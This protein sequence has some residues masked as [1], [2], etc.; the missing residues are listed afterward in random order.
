[1]AA[2]RKAARPPRISSRKVAG[3][4]SQVLEVLGYGITALE[5]ASARFCVVGGLARGYLAEARSTKDVD[6]AVSTESEDEVDNLIRSLQSSGFV[7]RELFQKKDG[8]VATVRLTWR[9]LPT[10][11]DLLFRTSGIEQLVVRDAVLMVVLKGVTAPVIRR[12]HLI[13]MKLIAARAQD[14]IDIEALL[15]AATPAEVKAVPKALAGLVP[16]KR[17]KANAAWTEL[18]AKRRARKPD[19]FPAPERLRALQKLPR[20]RK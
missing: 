2:R 11:M 15:D 8:R 9:H 4:P 10:R 3:P 13:A 6:L 19:L 16:E 7:L 14:L 18:L 12:P 17:E 1:M 20:R 5:N